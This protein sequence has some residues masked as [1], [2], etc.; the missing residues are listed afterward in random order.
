MGFKCSGCVYYFGFVIKSE[1]SRYGL[2][3]R[4]DLFPF[5]TPSYP[6]RSEAPPHT[7]SLTVRYY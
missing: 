7:G 6:W 5:Y 1:I 2:K 3:F 4:R